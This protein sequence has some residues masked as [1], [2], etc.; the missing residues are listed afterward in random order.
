[1]RPAKGEGAGAGVGPGADWVTT[2]EI[3]GAPGGRGGASFN[4]TGTERLVSGAEFCAKQNAPSKQ[5]RVTIKQFNFMVG[6]H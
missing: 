1:M 2:G 4:R 6:A 3:A 5:S